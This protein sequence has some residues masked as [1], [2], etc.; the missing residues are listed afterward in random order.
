MTL[1]TKILLEPDHIRLNPR[2]LPALKTRSRVPPILK[3]VISSR[4]FPGYLPRNRLYQ[5]T[6]T[7][8]IDQQKAIIAGLA[9][10]FECTKR[11]VALVTL[12]VLHRFRHAEH[13]LLVEVPAHDLHSD[14]KRIFRLAA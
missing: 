9:V 10:P 4:A 6:R 12:S 11:T 1:T 14:W 5:H 7:H 8:R 3:L 2:K 13:R